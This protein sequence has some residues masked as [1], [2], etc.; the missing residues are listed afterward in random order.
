MKFSSSPDAEKKILEEGWN[1]Y[2][3]GDLPM[4]TTVVL[5]QAG[6]IDCV[7]SALSETVTLQHD[8]TA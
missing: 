5:V 4:V 3:G 7:I 8:V 1:D 2:I 6:D